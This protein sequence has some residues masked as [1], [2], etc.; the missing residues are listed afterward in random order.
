MVRKQELSPKAYY[1]AKISSADICTYLITIFDNAS[2]WI[3]CGNKA[4]DLI[5]HHFG[6]MFNI[7]HIENNIN[8]PK[9]YA[10]LDIMA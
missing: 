10:I 7:Q 9:Y 2:L 8:K 5:L 1:T 4:C 6:K 3:C